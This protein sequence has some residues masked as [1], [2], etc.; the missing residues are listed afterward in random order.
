[1]PHAVWGTETFMK[2]HNNLTAGSRPRSNRSLTER[3]I[4]R[5]AKQIE[6]DTMT[7]REAIYTRYEKFEEQLAHCYFLLH[8]RFIADPPLARFWAE[9]AMD[10]LQ[11]FS[12]LRF[13]RERGLMANVEPRADTTHN[14][15][16][17]LETVKCLIADPDITVEEAFYASLLMESSELEEVYER[18]VGGLERDHPLL[19]QA[20]HSS[21]QSHL[22]EFKDAAEQFCKDSG[23]IEAF[24]NMGRSAS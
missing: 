1:M 12:I 14:I 18:L 4:I 22:R 10:E 24:R 7:E 13:C 23:F 9:A 21:L 3:Q 2:A 5:F 19:Y 16:D 15:E 6:E 20:I 8:E 17:L 11:H